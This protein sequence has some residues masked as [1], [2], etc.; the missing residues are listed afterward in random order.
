MDTGAFLP[1]LKTLTL[2]TRK[3]KTQ[4]PV[5]MWAQYTQTTRNGYKLRRIEQITEQH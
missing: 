4:P 5:R 3:K 2:P 1:N